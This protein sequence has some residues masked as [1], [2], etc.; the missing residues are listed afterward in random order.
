MAHQALHSMRFPR[1]EKFPISQASGKFAWE[2]IAMSW[3]G[4]PCVP[5]GDLPNPGIELASL[6]SPA[7]AGGFLFFFKPLVSLGNPFLPV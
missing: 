3:S 4:L 2:W 6:K 1:E 5:P 7:L